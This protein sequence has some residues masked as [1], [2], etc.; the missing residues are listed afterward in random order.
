NNQPLR[1]GAVDDGDNTEGEGDLPIQ[2]ATNTMEEPA[3]TDIVG[4][5]MLLADDLTVSGVEAL[6]AEARLLLE[7][8]YTPAPPGPLERLHSRQIARYNGGNDFRRRFNCCAE[9]SLSALA[10]LLQHPVYFEL[11]HYRFMNQSASLMDQ[12]APGSVLFIGNQG[13]PDWDAWL[14]SLDNT[15]HYLLRRGTQ[16]GSG[17]HFVLT[18]ADNEWFAIDTSSRYPIQLTQNGQALLASCRLLF[19]PEDDEVIWGGGFAEYSILYA[20]VNIGTLARLNAY[21]RE[22]RRQQHQDRTNQR[23]PPQR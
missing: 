10:L 15:Q 6:L 3:T 12:F 14:A 18:Y 8:N 20:P 5:E 16:V 17:H 4:A 2:G 19:N 11:T 1:V 9:Y 22:Q 23:Q 21:L 13:E 7:G